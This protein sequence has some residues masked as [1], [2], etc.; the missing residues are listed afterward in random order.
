[1]LAGSCNARWVS[2][3]VDGKRTRALTFVVNRD[4]G[5]YLAAEPLDVIAHLVRTGTGPLGNMRDYF[6]LTRQA[7]ASRGIRDAGIERLKQAIVR[8]DQ[9]RKLSAPRACASSR[10]RPAARR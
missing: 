9:S 10:Q 6:V 2:A 5:R 1:M 7:L 8:L 3:E 4:S